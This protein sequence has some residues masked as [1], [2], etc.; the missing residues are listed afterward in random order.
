MTKINPDIEA[1]AR[2]KVIGVGNSGT[3]AVNHMMRSKV[4]G[5]EFIVIDTDAQKLH[6]S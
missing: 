3:N 1:F 5:V 2:I 6:H 4:K